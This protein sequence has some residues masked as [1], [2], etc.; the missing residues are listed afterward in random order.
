MATLI[1][2]TTNL[3]GTTVA[4]KTYQ[5]DWENPTP[6]QIRTARL[7]LKQIATAAAV[8]EWGQFLAKCLL[9]LTDPIEATPVAEIVEPI[10]HG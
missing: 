1:D 4:T 8:P 5:K 6:A 9:V 3:A 10:P 2:E 7:Q